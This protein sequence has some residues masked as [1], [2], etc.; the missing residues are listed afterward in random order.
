MPFLCLFL[1]SFLGHPIQIKPLTLSMYANI[2]DMQDEV[3][4]P[5]KREYG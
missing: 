2:K 4:D 3:S 5:R 1:S